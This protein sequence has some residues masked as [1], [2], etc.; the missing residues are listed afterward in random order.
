MAEIKPSYIYLDQIRGGFLGLALGDALGAPHEF[1]YRRPVSEYTGKLEYTI[2]SR[3]PYQPIRY[4]V[5]GQVTDDTTMSAAL[6]RSIVKNKGWKR[7]EVI[8]AYLAWANPSKPYVMPF[9]GKNTRKLLKGVKTIKG[10]ETRHAK[11]ASLEIESNGSLMR[12]FPLVLLF[13]YEDPKNPERICKLALEDTDLTNPNDVNRNAVAVYLLILANVLLGRSPVFVLD[14]IERLFGDEPA[15]D[16]IYQAVRQAGSGDTRDVTVNSGW[17]AHAIYLLVRGWIAIQN[18]RN[19][20]SSVINW[21][22]EQGG[23]TDTNACIVGSLLGFYL[24]EDYM[25]SEDAITSENIKILLEMDT[26]EGDLPFDPK[27]LPKG[28]M[29]LLTPERL[30][31]S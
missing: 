29:K 23:D 2:D 14:E 12:A 22:I 17:V 21:V 11:H 8:Q 24:G 25:T 7:D 18:S 31:F 27:L 13:I 26:S 30:G 28:V 10:Y 5:V 20:Y 15:S 3:A 19:S 6:L 16:P 9:M 1:S 4:S